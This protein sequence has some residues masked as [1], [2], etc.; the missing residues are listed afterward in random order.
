T[1]VLPSIWKNV[2]RAETRKPRTSIRAS[3][4]APLNEIEWLG[5]GGWASAEVKFSAET[6]WLPGTI[7]RR[8][9]H[10][11]LPAPAPSRTPTAIRSVGEPDRR[12]TVQ[13][14][15]PLAGI[16]GRTP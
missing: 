5:A 4:G 3:A 2:P 7:A 8:T 1:L 10:R 13:F 14:A 6:G 9:I 12:D 16:D 15:C 11:S